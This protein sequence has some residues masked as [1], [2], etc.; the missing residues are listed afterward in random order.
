MHHHDYTLVVQLSPGELL[1]GEGLEQREAV[2]DTGSCAAITADPATNL[3][4]DC[5]VT[6]FLPPMRNYPWF[7]EL[8]FYIP[9]ILLL[10]VKN[11]DGQNKILFCESCDK[12]W[13]NYDLLPLLFGCVLCIVYFVND[14]RRICNC[15]LMDFRNTR[16][17]LISFSSRHF[18]LFVLNLICLYLE[19]LNA[20]GELVLHLG[21]GSRLWE[22][23][24]LHRPKSKVWSFA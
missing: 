22:S 24:S 10:F 19:S 17:S 4:K 6:C 16:T 13:L 5:E 2:L 1:G 12:I 9:T 11:D 3:K 18:S 23:A 15:I 8:Y 21:G 20:A 14:V 7:G